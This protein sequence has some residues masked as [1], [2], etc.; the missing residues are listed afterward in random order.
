MDFGT[1]GIRSRPARDQ[2]PIARKFIFRKQFLEQP[3][4]K[5]GVEYPNEFL[6]GF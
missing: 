2:V 5:G 1:T 4:N 3:L 6:Q